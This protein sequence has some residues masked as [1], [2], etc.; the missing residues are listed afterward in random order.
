ML[1]YSAIY[2]NNFL[3]YYYLHIYNNT[4]IY[5]NKPIEIPMLTRESTTIDLC[6]LNC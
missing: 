2:F 4:E 6:L 5:N 1:C 3:K